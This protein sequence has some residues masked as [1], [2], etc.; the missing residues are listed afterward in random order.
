VAALVIVDVLSFATAVTVAAEAGTRVYPWPWRGGSA[1]E[2]ARQR[3]AELASGRELRAAGF[4]D[5][6]AIAAELDSASIVPVLAG[7]A[8]RAESDAPEN[9]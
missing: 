5:D 9:G 8:F 6:V 1:A 4:A 7:G 2:F 3:N